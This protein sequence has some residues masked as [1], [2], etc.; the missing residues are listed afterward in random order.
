M[1]LLLQSSVTCIL[2][3]RTILRRIQLEGDFDP[4]EVILSSR[5][6]IKDDPPE[7]P[8]GG[9]TILVTTY[10]S[11]QEQTVQQGFAVCKLFVFVLV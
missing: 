7:D 8:T 3:L 1:L 6:R 9:C 2:L 5:V 11:R 4:P 10:A